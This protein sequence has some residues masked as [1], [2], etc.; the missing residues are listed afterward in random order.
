MLHGLL[1]QPE[2]AGIPVLV[3]ANK[4]D[5]PGAITPHE[6]QARFGLG[7]AAH[8]GS[9]QPMNVLGVIAHSGDGVEEGVIWLVDTLR[10]H[11]RTTGLPE[12]PDWKTTPRS[13]VHV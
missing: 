6:I 5:A 8:D 12:E 13:P 9:T 4:Q 10:N 2:L 3:F 11:P 1:Q 7:Q